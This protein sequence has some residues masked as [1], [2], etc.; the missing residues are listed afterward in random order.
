MKIRHI[1][2][3]E[4]FGQNHFWHVPQTCP[5]VRNPTARPARF[6][7]VDLLLGSCAHALSPSFTETFAFAVCLLFREDHLFWLLL[8][9]PAWTGRIGRQTANANVWVKDGLHSDSDSR[10]SPDDSIHDS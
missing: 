9:G 6:F 5:D 7:R 4:L 3:E 8:V 2:S 1:W 10:P